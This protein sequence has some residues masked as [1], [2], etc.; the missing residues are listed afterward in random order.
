ME[1]VK[2]SARVFAHGG[3]HHRLDVALKISLRLL[4]LAQGFEA[5]DPHTGQGGGRAA[6]VDA[7]ARFVA[8]VLRDHRDLVAEGDKFAEKVLRIDTHPRDRGEITAGEKTDAH[9]WKRCQP[10]ARDFS[11]RMATTWRPGSRYRG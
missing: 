3:L 2:G 9:G 4:L 10:S 8:T 1:K 7:G 5:D 11:L 6:A